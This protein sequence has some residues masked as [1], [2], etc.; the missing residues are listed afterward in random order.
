MYTIDVM[1]T[2]GGYMK[3]LIHRII[4]FFL[5]F[6]LFTQ[7]EDPAAWW[8]LDE[9]KGTAVSDS[10]KNKIPGRIAGATWVK[11]LSGGALYFNGN[12]SVFF[13]NPEF[14]AFEEDFSISL[15]VKPET[16][17]DQVFIS[18]WTGS[19]SESG[20]WI[21]L[22]QKKINFRANNGSRYAFAVGEPSGK[23]VWQHIAAV[24][25]EDKILLYLN[26]KKVGESTAGSGVIGNNAAEV[27]LGLNAIKAW[28][29]IGAMD[30][31]KIF[32]H[33]LSEDEI[34]KTYTIFK[35]KAVQMSGVS[36]SAVSAASAAAEKKITEPVKKMSGPVFPG[37]KW[38][39]RR[40][41]NAALSKDYID[42][43]MIPG[44]DV[45]IDDKQN[46]V[47][48]EGDSAGKYVG[49]VL[50]GKRIQVP[51]YIDVLGVYCEYT[52]SC[53][54]D[55]RVPFLQAAVFSEEDWDALGKTPEDRIPFS[56]KPLISANVTASAG[57]GENITAWTPWQSENLAQGSLLKLKAKTVVVA[58][59]FD[60]SQG[61]FEDKA[62]FRNI[63]LFFTGKDS[64]GS[65]FKKS[66]YGPKTART[67]WTPEET[68]AARNMVNTDQT[69][70]NIL[71]GL[72]N[73]TAF[74]V[75]MKPEEIRWR[76]TPSDVPRAFNVGTMGCPDCGKDIYKRGTYPEIIDPAQPFK[77]KCPLCGKLFPDNDYFAYYMSDF[78]DKKALKGQYSDN[79]WGWKGP[80]EKF[81]FVAYYN[82]WFYDKY[83]IPGL[84]DLSRA[85]LLTGDIKYG[86]AAALMLIRLAEVYPEMDYAYQSRYGE[87]MSGKYPG[88]ILNSIWEAQKTAQILPEAYDNIYDVFSRDT[89]LSTLSEH[90]NRSLRDLQDFIEANI[91]DDIITH[92]RGAKIRGNFG[93]HQKALL[94]A[95]IAR[96]TGP[97][98]ETLNWLMKNE[99]NEGWGSM[100]IDW[101]LFNYVFKDGIPYES[102][103][104]NL[105]WVNEL[106]SMAPQLAKLGVNMISDIKFHQ[107]TAYSAKLICGDTFTP[108]LGDGGN[109]TSGPFLP[110]LSAL[111]TGYIASRDT[112]I[113]KLLSRANYSPGAVISYEDIFN[114]DKSWVTDMERAIQTGGSSLNFPSRAF[115]GYGL[116]ILNDRKNLVGTSVLYGLHGA[117]THYDRLNLDSFALGSRLTP[118]LGYPDFMNAFVP[119]IYSWSINSVS[120]N[121][122]VVNQ[123]RQDSK[124]PGR[125]VHLNDLAMVH[126]MTMH[127]DGTYDDTT[128]YRRI[129]SVIEKPAGLSYMI[130]IFD[131]A[132]GSQH[133]F[134]FH[135]PQG[136]FEI[137]HITLGSPQTE[138]TLAGKGIPY[139]A[140][141]DDP[142][143]GKAGYKGSFAGYKGSGFSHLENVQRARPGAPFTAR[144]NVAQKPGLGFAFHA[145]PKSDELFVCDGKVSPTG[146]NNHVLKYLLQRNTGKDVESVFVSVHEPYWEKSSITKIREIPTG[147][148]GK[149]GTPVC[150]EVSHESTDYFFSLPDRQRV[151]IKVPVNKESTAEGI[152]VQAQ[153]ALVRLSREREF[154][155]AWMINGGSLEC[156]PLM[157]TQAGMITG[158]VVSLQPLTREVT[159]SSDKKNRARLLAGQSIVIYNEA[160]SCRYEIQNA[161]ET[162]AGLVLTLG[163]SDLITGKSII[164]SADP[165]A[166]TMKLRAQ[167]YMPERYAG[168]RAA[169]HDYAW[170]S[171]VIES[172]GDDGTLTFAAADKKMPSVHTGDI[173][174]NTVNMLDFGPG[175]DFRIDCITAVD[176][177]GKGVFTVHSSTPVRLRFS[178]SQQ[179]IWV[180]DGKN[181]WSERKYTE[182]G[183]TLRTEDFFNQMTAIVTEKPSWMVLDDIKPPQLQDVMVDGKKISVSS[184]SA[185]IPLGWLK[186]APG[187]ILL[188]FT[189]DKNPINENDTE[190]RLNKASLDKKLWSLESVDKKKI[191]TVKNLVLSEDTH[192]LEVTVRD[193]APLAN[194]CSVSIEMN[195]AAQYNCA[196]DANGGKVEVDSRFNESY[197]ET[198]L[199]DGVVPEAVGSGNS[200]AAAEISEPHWI[201][202]SFA[203]TQTVDRV[204]IFWAISSLGTMT[205]RAYEIQYLDGE[206]W[207]T[208]LPVKNKTA[209]PMSEHIFSPVNTQ[210][211]RIWQPAEMGPEAKVNYMWVSEVR[212]FRKE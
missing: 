30:E 129:F 58:L 80:G 97:T 74:W 81:W 140:L 71:Q 122:V 63:T 145:L 147:K 56:V 195:V 83:T 18:R 104:Y 19:G 163:G 157:I 87:L 144:W 158:K 55:D 115:D 106:A 151:S 198:P 102:L 26:G 10:S 200:W 207:K 90:T 57:T 34:M 160:H 179:N 119:G 171:P 139:G 130:D 53:T 21:G 49:K 24:R 62:G 174:K 1:R 25:E 192:I 146:K 51:N 92:I 6:P 183:I 67:L 189:D 126:A 165:D 68:A 105:I 172:A 32:S 43:G 60:G 125:L 193:K 168:M 137:E 184:D 201:A 149:Q 35:D 141:Y 162:G 191:I 75:N 156:G 120:H 78:Q 33:A 124:F 11:G 12:A 148:A 185:V 211:L 132:G 38:E 194:S 15:W 107:L 134:S 116:V 65:T 29:F 88:K 16:D 17:S 159:L 28:K 72:I 154:E 66:I 89:S 44:W 45:N 48:I 113:A 150:I 54:R 212:V 135:G 169:S 4:F 36:A 152:T 155:S 181:I 93:M 199:N 209:S 101:A 23:G 203:E 14:T 111:K 196:L 50:V 95:L 173:K 143:L 52:A 39:A 164:G 94:T 167:L 64:G 180:R 13:G 59:T 133:D 188:T 186:K 5:L 2:I 166:G 117:H 98:E 99:G 9:E 61:H 142:A 46:I 73:R 70:K 190:V 86:R 204:Q 208:A 47:L 205:S 41:I 176:Q 210:R 37:G 69:A 40:A 175:D 3:L 202:I 8:K 27:T 20:W 161:K 128:R 206:T 77:V 82:H 131:V 136:S 109:L 79:G 153:K 42:G 100:G 197:S 31:V 22:Y 84:L 187:T 110:Q 178:S 108:S 112:A 182:A 103:G 123:K 114:S 91:L 7:A 121:T 96:Q 138:G 177:T 170:I 76:I 118:D 127:A 85:Y